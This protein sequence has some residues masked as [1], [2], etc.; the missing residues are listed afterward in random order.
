LTDPRS[1]AI[2]REAYERALQLDPESAVARHDLA[3]LDARGHRPARALRGLIEAGQLDPSEPATIRAVTAVLW[4]LSWRLRMWLVV[5]TL[6]QLAASWTVL[7]SR[8]VAAVVLAASAG[9]GWLTVRDLPRQALPVVRGAVRT[10]RPLTLT[11]LALA[12]C[13]FVYVVILVSGVGVAAAAVWAVL[14]GLGWLALIIRIFRRR[15]A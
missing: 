4:Q 12:F 1:T 7:G 6:G 2:A 10:D 8:I 9:L 15:R 13:L 5:A 11:Y 14:I 3:V